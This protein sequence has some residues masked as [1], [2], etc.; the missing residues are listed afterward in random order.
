[1]AS[2]PTW[3]ARVIQGLPNLLAVWGCETFYQVLGFVYGK[4]GGL[5]AFV[6]PFF[7][8]LLLSFG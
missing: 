7:Y 3:D 5:R 6:S 8:A 1:M 4:D 2:L